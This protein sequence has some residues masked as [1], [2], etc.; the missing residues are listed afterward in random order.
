M[1]F[2]VKCSVTRFSEGGFLVVMNRESVYICGLFCSIYRS[3][4]LK[5]SVEL[6]YDDLF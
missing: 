2:L 4:K 6:G 3:W 1:E 5:L